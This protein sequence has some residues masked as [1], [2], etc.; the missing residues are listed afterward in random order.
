MRQAKTD[1]ITQVGK[2]IAILRF[3]HQHDI[4]SLQWWEYLYEFV[5]AQSD[6]LHGQ[7]RISDHPHIS[8]VK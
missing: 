5:R 1:A 7:A 4:T 6:S 3:T 8:C 2:G